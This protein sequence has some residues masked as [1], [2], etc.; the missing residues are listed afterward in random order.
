MIM[1]N[2]EINEYVVFT[3]IC[4]ITSMFVLPG[5]LIVGKATTVITI[6][7]LILLVLT[8]VLVM[9]FVSL[10]YESVIVS[11]GEPTTLK[12]MIGIAKASKKLKRNGGKN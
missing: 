6:F 11:N 1:S 12:Q 5:A 8:N 10:V 9:I 2:V 7:A 4:P 3:M